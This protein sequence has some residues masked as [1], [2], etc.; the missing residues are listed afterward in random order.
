LCFGKVRHTKIKDDTGNKLSSFHPRSN[1]LYIK[2]RHNVTDMFLELADNLTF[3]LSH[4][5]TSP[6][7]G[8]LYDEKGAQWLG[9]TYFDG[10][11]FHMRIDI[12]IGM[13]KPL[14]RNDLT[15]RR[16]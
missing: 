10:V 12:D 7:T 14:L 15:V 1:A 16:S 8:L 2:E 6:F 4:G 13:L 5:A 9:V 11:R 3:G